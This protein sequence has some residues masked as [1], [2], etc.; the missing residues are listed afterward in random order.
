M[1]NALGLLIGENKIVEIDHVDMDIAG[2]RIV[3]NDGKAYEKT[4]PVHYGEEVTVWLPDCETGDEIE[5]IKEKAGYCEII[6]EKP[7][8]Q[9]DGRLFARIRSVLGSA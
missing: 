2:G 7:F 3:L 5:A 9:P 1:R 4:E 8:A 6:V